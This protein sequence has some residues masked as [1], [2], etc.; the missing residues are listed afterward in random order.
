MEYNVK[1]M[2]KAKLISGIVAGLE[3]KDIYDGIVS[4]ANG[5]STASILGELFSDYMGYEKESGYIAMMDYLI[6]TYPDSDELIQI[7]KLNLMRGK[8]AS[9]ADIR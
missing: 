9:A 8:G 4:V 3:Q 6:A 5:E 7:T 1:I 2:I